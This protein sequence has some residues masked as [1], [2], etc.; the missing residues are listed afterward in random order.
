MKNCIARIALSMVLMFTFASFVMAQPGFSTIPSVHFAVKY[1]KGIAEED[2]K[3]VAEYLEA[4]HAYL[5]KKLAL[6][7]LKPPLEVRVYASAG[8][9]LEATAQQKPWRG[10]LLHREIIHVQPVVEIMKKRIFEKSLSYELALAFLEP[11]SGKGSPRWLREA[12]AVHHSGVMADLRPPIETRISAFS[13]L[14]QDLQQY[15]TPPQ[16]SDVLFLLGQ[17]LKFF[18]EQYGEEKALAV[19]KAFDGV[20]SLEDIFKAHFGKDFSVIEKEWAGYIARQIEP[21]KKK[22]D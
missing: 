12:F 11:T 20:H 21:I 1:Q 17:T 19:Y 4:D 8:K 5:T 3:R 6:S 15:P 14:D 18:S 7:L 10:A 16:R 2:A 13:D 22:Q 9:Y